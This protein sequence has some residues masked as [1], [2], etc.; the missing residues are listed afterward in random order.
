MSYEEVA[1]VLEC[2]KATV[3]RRLNR[4]R[5]QLGAILTEDP[6]TPTPNS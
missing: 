1:E 5:L 6:R 2:S 4:G 3:K